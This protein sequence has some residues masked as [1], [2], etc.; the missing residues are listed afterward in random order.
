M[1]AL[2]IRIAHKFMIFLRTCAHGVFH[3]LSE[4]MFNHSPVH[5]YC[6]HSQL[7]VHDRVS[8]ISPVHCY[9]RHSQL[10]ASQH[11]EVSCK[12]QCE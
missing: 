7:A 10:V 9:C 5:C 12:L 6:S 8:W 2:D 11:N 1:S 4:Y 3:G